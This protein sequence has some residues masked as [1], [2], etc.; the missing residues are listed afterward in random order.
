LSRRRLIVL[1]LVVGTAVAVYASG[2][3][4]ELPDAKTVIGDI[5]RGL[6]KW[7]YLLVG[8]LA[9]LETGA[10]VGL[11]APGETVVIAGGVIAGQGEISLTLLIGIVWACAFLG[12]TTSFFIGRRLGRGFILR[13]GPKVKITEARLEQVESFF[14]RHG[15]KT[16]LIGRFVGLVRALAPFIA[17]SSGLSY[18]RF[19]P[20]SVVGTG[21]WAA[22]FSVL[23]FIFYASFDRVAHIAGQA[24][25]AFGVTVAVIA[26]AV[27]A[28][29]RLRDE[30]QRRRVEAWIEARPVLGSLWRRAVRP[31]WQLTAPRVRFVWQRL[32]PG[33]L[34]LELT[35][36]LAFATVGLYVF[37]LY[38]VVLS[39]DPGP[40]VLDTEI[41]DLIVDLR[42]DV[43]VDITKLVTELGSLPVV[44]A[45]VVASSFVLAR[46]RVWFALWPLVAGATLVYLAVQLAKAGIDRPR[47][48]GSLVET[49]G[50]AFP[51]GHAAY[52]TAWVMVAAIAAWYVPGLVR[53]AAIVGFAFIV[54]AVVGLSRVYL[55]AH[56]WSDI[57]AGWGLGF[58]IFGTCAAVALVVSY[59]RQNEAPSSS[60]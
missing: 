59:I 45:L 23:G 60:I 41:R 36:A 37:I 21:L 22:L 31:A 5:A 10:F 58:G 47:P 26:G 43:V 49:S 51:S 28:W 3:L 29:R 55:G 15:G 2:V 9:F 30:E 57:A 34:G 6:G 46:R 38:A 35:T 11:V 17:G 1:A 8:L 4:D 54:V 42:L 19:A 52:S 20:Y 32:T 53:D 16:I 39:G 25:F 50:Q 48:A 44:A 13:H 18:G 27:F 12:D 33:E 7:T 14:Q 24:T 40:T 56:W